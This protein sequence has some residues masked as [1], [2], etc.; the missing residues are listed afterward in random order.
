LKQA[1]VRRNGISKLLMIGSDATKKSYRPANTHIPSVEN[2]P[3]SS[4][5]FYI[6]CPLSSH[7]VLRNVGSDKHAIP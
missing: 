2:L 4:I 5:L 7:F 6:L 1:T 3:S